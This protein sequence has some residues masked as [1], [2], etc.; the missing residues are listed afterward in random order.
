MKVHELIK[1]LQ[2]FED[3]EADVFVIEHSSG[4]GYYD[5]GGNIKEAVFNK[6]EHL[7]YVDFRGNPHV[8]P[9]R[10]CFNARTLLI[11][12]RDN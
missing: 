9:D 12:S 1:V 11:G 6:D 4:D 5:Q 3:Q 2:E 10:E 7:E 8:K